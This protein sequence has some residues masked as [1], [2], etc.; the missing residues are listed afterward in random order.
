[1]AWSSGKDSA[2]ALH[3]AREA[4]DLE[5]VGLL[6]TLTEPY[7]RISMHAVRDDLLQAQADAVGL[8][9]HRVIIPSPCTDEQYAAAM[10]AS[11]EAAKADGVSHV[12]FGEE[13]R[14]ALHFR[15]GGEERDIAIVD[16]LFLALVVAAQ[17]GAAADAERCDV[18]A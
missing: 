16:P 12:V 15:V 18:W 3:V 11:M 2:W 4:G 8:P 17:Q 14:D 6:T 5:V 7:H 9:V 10:Q 1:M 13:T